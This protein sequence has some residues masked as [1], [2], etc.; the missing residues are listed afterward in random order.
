MPQSQLPD[1]NTM[2]LKWTDYINTCLVNKDYLG[3][4][5]GVYHINAIFGADNRVEINTEKYHQLTKE[6]LKIKCPFCN[7]EI[8]NDDVKS[9]DLLN[10]LL[11]ELITETKYDKVWDCPKCKQTIKMQDT[12]FIQEHFLSPK[13]NGV[14]PE[15][16]IRKTGISGTKNYERESQWW[17]RIT[18]DELA[19]ALGNER[20]EYVPVVDRAD[21]IED[22]GADENNN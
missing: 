11:A 15:P 9:Y 3:A 17:I 12:E 16:P 1:L 20:R 8:I 22:E 7:D 2:W 18:L 14:V 10:P 5:S 6:L 21:V 13:Y 4:I 19:H